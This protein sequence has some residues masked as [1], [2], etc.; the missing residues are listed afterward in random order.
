LTSFPLSEAKDLLARV[1]V[2]DSAEA[3]KQATDQ[4]LA[5]AGL[6]QLIRVRR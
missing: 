6:Q 5:E 2:L 3:V 1:L 4:A